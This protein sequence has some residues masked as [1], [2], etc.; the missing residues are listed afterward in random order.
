MTLNIDGDL[1][2]PSP[3]V[4]ASP[5][6]PLRVAIGRPV[7]SGKTALTDA[8]CKTMRDRFNIAAVTND[9][10]TQGDAQ[11][12]TRSEALTADRIVGVKT[13]GCPHIAIREGASMNLAAIA[14][15][16]AKFSSSRFDLYRVRRR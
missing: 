3:K 1:A 2:P 14:D 9:I 13:G 6:G 16:G 10:Y 15:L 11:F 8:L 7:G 5:N 4:G 12:L